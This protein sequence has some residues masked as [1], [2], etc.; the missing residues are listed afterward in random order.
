M[1][2][3]S[4]SR[5]V[6]QL[7]LSLLAGFS[8]AGAGAAQAQE[9]W[10]S[11]GLQPVAPSQMRTLDPARVDMTS[12]LYAEGEF[13]IRIVPGP[14]LQA[15]AAA[16]EAF[17]RAASRWEAA[18]R[19][20]MFVTINADLVGS[21]PPNA[22]A[23]TAPVLLI[24]PTA[25]AADLLAM[26]AAQ[27]PADA[28]AL[29]LPT[30][31]A[32]LTALLP[33]GAVLDGSVLFA[34]A[35]V[36][37]LGVDADSAFGVSDGQIV[38]NNT[39]PFDY[40]NRNGVGAGQVD[41]ETAAAHEI[42]HLLGFLS[43]L[44]QVEAGAFTSSVPPTP[45]DLFRFASTPLATPE[46]TNEFVTLPRS[47]Q[48]GVAASFDDIAHELM[49]STGVSGDGRQASH[50]KANELTGI[51]L[52]VM[53]PT[54]TVQEVVP[55]SAGD[56]RALDLIGYDILA[57]E[58]FPTLAV[59]ARPG[60]GATGNVIGG[61]GVSPVV[62]AN[63]P[64]ELMATAADGDGLGF[65]VLADFGAPAR[66]P[67]LWELGGREP[68]NG[69][70][71]VFGSSPVVRFDLPASMPGLTVP[72]SVNAYD[73]LGDATGRTLAVRVS[74]PPTVVIQVPGMTGA[75]PL[76]L[77]SGMPIRM[78]ARVTD[79][80]GI[81]FPIYQRLGNN[82]LIRYVWAFPG[83]DAPGLAV[84]AEEP[85]VTFRLPAGQA[86]AT[87]NVSLT[88]YDALGLSATQNLAVY[89]NRPPALTFRV[90]GQAAGA[91]ISIVS[92]AR[93]QFSTTVS[94]ADGLGFP[95]FSAFGSN[96][97]ITH[98]WD[99]DGAQPPSLA[100]FAA[101]P[102]VTFTLPAGVNA[103]TFNVAL[104]VFDAQGFSTVRLLQVNVRR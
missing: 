52:G 48:L 58:A 66:V 83:A 61:D 23:G 3:S 87:Y 89:V 32:S 45:L 44:D 86:S 51:S 78:Q 11:C 99:F 46:T 75:G 74:Q 10:K 79:L 92:G 15:N 13:Q 18:I 90:N 43:V 102:A 38:F 60:P 40:D 36:K 33:P 1:N 88:G 91:S 30:A 82:A 29:L 73:T 80:E 47:L 101:S 24:G 26:D 21:L 98:V 85:V 69:P 63:T 5:T 59:V 6:S 4:D 93:V 42:G 16:L 100:N 81:G 103:R 70:L 8:L 95:V 67:F 65:P 20:P 54:L 64:V 41:F 62:A 84:F 9:E 25:F 96:V 35:T 56:K 72:I 71:A 50:W 55:V 17:E 97:P 31:A 94:D 27:E 7:L 53:D 28:V 19:D 39:A 12:E 49:M 57:A 2:V 77:P 14:G 22:L 76:R 37:A 34:K 104:S 68:L